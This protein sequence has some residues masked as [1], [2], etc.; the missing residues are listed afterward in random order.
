MQNATSRMLCFDFLGKDVFWCDTDRVHE[1]T[2]VVQRSEVR[3]ICL[4]DRLGK[5]NYDNS[6]SDEGEKTVLIV[7]QNAQLI[8]F[9]SCPR[10][11]GKKILN[12]GKLNLSFGGIR[13][14]KL[15]ARAYRKKVK[16]ILILLKFILMQNYLKCI[17]NYKQFSIEIEFVILK[18]L[19]IT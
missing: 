15:L 10:E 8:P 3:N 9:N 14:E 4:H 16:M 6:R 17:K 7:T 19:R 5:K 13:L 2:D 11:I 12:N 18:I 1:W